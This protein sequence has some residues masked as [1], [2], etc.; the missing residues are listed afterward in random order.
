MI[1]SARFV[2]GLDEIEHDDKHLVGEHAAH[3]GAI[4][5]LNILTPK[6]FVVTPASYF[7]FLRSN[8]LDSKIGH[9]LGSINF[10]IPESISQVSTHIKNLINKSPL[11]DKLIDEIFGEYEKLGEGYVSIH[12]SIISGDTDQN[13]FPREYLFDSIEGESALA[14]LLRNFWASLFD[15]ALIKYR[16]EKQI[17]HLKTGIAATIK[18]NSISGL[19][20][21]IYT[22]DLHFQDKTKIVIEPDGAGVHYVVDKNDRTYTSRKNPSSIIVY[23]KDGSRHSGLDP[24][25][26]FDEL[27]NLAADIENHFYFPQEITWVNE[28]GKYK[29]LSVKPINLYGN[30]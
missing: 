26:E 30:N 24:Q 7:E 17:D 12:T 27:V 16:F 28:N 9:L 14:E 15:E 13:H 1:N 5:S 8:N 11:P 23:I 20:G 3:L 21:K 10:E 19:T 18:K 25:I 29:V 4:R 22:L 2:V 6:G